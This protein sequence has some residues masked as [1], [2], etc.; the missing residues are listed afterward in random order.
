MDNRGDE[1]VGERF[2]SWSCTCH[3]KHSYGLD[4]KSLPPAHCMNTAVLTALFG[5]S[6]GPLSIGTLLE[7]VGPQGQASLAVDA[8]LSDAM[9]SPL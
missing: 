3:H 9:L 1:C 4:V 6:A 8:L 5:K 7:E 2:H